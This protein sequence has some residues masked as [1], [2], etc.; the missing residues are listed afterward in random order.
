M[1]T[2]YWLTEPVNNIIILKIHRPECLNALNSASLL[3]LK[4][5]LTAIEKDPEI[6][7]LIITGSGD[8]AFVS[9]GDIDEIAGLS[10]ET[11]R[12]LTSEANKLMKYIENFPKP[13]IAA[14]N[15]I[16]FGGGSELAMVCHLRIA[17]E[18]AQFALP[19]AKLGI[20]TGMGGIQRMVQLV[21]KGKTYELAMTG[22]PVSAAEAEKIGLVNKVVSTDHLISTS[23]EI[24][25]KITESSGVSLRAIIKSI[26]AYYDDSDGFRLEMEEFEKCFG[27]NDFQEGVKAFR[28]KRKP[29]FNRIELK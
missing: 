10:P 24:L 29:D 22:D 19:E 25:K 21:G 7:G 15:G 8:K 26:N 2:R 12:K 20:I 6:T 1:N 11:A 23:M 9:G 17:S 28:E 13:I 14:V 3:E 5:I 4:E 27:E 16:A 18:N